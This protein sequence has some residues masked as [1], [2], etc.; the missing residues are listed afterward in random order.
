MADKYLHGGGLNPFWVDEQE[1]I[2]NTNNDSYSKGYDDGFD[3]G[4]DAAFSYGFSKGY[5]QAIKDIL[6]GQK[7][8]N[9]IMCKIIN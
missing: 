6:S 8:L 9:R 4:Y 1:K 7:I 3:D 2:Y 5:K